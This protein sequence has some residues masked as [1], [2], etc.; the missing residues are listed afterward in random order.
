MTDFLFMY[1][2]LKHVSFNE[3]IWLLRMSNITSTAQ[4]FRYLPRLEL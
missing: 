4:D 1:I 3:L 2:I